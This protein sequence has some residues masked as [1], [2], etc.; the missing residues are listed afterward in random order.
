[1]TRVDAPGFR[2]LGGFNGQDDSSSSLRRVFLT[3]STHRSRAISFLPAA[4]PLKSEL[5][6]EVFDKGQVR[7]WLQAE[8]LSPDASFRFIINDREVS[9]SEVRAWGAPRLRRRPALLR[10]CTSGVEGGHGE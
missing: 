4:I 8:H 5:A 10:G 3:G 2:V 9:D 7:F 6:Y 1:M